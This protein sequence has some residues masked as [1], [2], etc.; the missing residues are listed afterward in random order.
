MAQKE[1]IDSC[2]LVSLKIKRRLDPAEMQVVKSILN[3]LPRSITNRITSAATEFLRKTTTQPQKKV[4]LEDW[5]YTKVQLIRDD[6]NGFIART[7]PNGNLISDDL[8]QH[9]GGLVGDNE[10]VVG[11]YP[12]SLNIWNDIKNTGASSKGVLER[13]LDVIVKDRPTYLDINLRS[14]YVGL[15]SYYRSLGVSFDGPFSTLSYD[16]ARLALGTNTI[17]TYKEPQRVISCRV[18]KFRIPL[19]NATWLNNDKI[20]LNVNEFS[21][22]G[23]IGQSFNHQ[24]EFDVALSPDTRH[25]ILTPITGADIVTFFSPL[26]IVDKM[27][28]M[29]YDSFNLMTFNPDRGIFTASN[30]NPA[31]F[32]G[33]T[34][35]LQTG[36][37]VLINNFVSTSQP[38]NQ[39]INNNYFTVTV[40]SSTQ[41]TIPVDFSGLGVDVSNIYVYYQGERILSP[42]T[43]QCMV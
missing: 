20:M 24:F 13:I 25:I 27:T 16:V 1:W 31:M 23:Y 40:I 22:T 9:D 38:L 29:F 21:H 28:L 7:Q 37:R 33:P 39:T 15:D 11:Q 26:P 42:F 3:E 6:E 32:T 14:S 35:S 43:F 34:N 10:A 17:Q 30:T 12:T 8:L 19:D 4:G 41:F 2:N 5:E 36:D 18:G